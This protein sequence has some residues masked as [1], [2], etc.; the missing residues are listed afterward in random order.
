[1]EIKD[2]IAPCCFKIPW[3]KYSRDGVSCLFVFSLC[4][5]DVYF[6]ARCSERFMRVFDKLQMCM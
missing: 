2:L 1:M 5:L 4:F 6:Q 3:A